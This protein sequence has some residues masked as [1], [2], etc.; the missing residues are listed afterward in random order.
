MF[1]RLAEACLQEHNVTRGAVGRS[2]VCGILA[3]LLSSAGAASV[4]DGPASDPEEQCLPPRE[5]SRVDS[6]QVGVTPARPAAG[7]PDR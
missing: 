1:A 5:F 2:V 7:G 3:L 6:I 4:A